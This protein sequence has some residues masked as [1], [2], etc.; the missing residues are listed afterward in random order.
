MSSPTS[1]KKSLASKLK[2]QRITNDLSSRETGVISWLKRENGIVTITEEH[3]VAFLSYEKYPLFSGISVIFRWF[4]IFAFSLHF[5]RFTTQLQ[6]FC[7]EKKVIQYNS[8]SAFLFLWIWKYGGH[9]FWACCWISALCRM[10]AMLSRRITK[11]FSLQQDGSSNLEFR[12]CFNSFV[13]ALYNL[14]LDLLERKHS[15]TRRN[16]PHFANE[17]AD[18]ILS[19]Q[20]KQLCGFQQYTNP[21]CL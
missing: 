18:P 2:L 11:L 13:S 8:P 5:W 19:P 16:C 1:P 10:F 9:L 21:S 20:E 15:C 3:F 17:S 14:F 4:N 6:T 7:G 12:R